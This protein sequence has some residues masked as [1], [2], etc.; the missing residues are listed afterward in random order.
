MQE[1]YEA[2]VKHRKLTW[3]YHAGHAN[4]RGNFKRN[5]IDMVMSTTQAAVVLLFNSGACSRSALRC[6]CCRWR[7]YAFPGNGET[8]C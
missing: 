3:Y 2:T 4:I 5:P 7:L 6:A 8:E 1:F